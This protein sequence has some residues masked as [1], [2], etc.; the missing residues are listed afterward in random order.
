MKD[1]KYEEWTAEDLRSEL[2]DRKLTKSGTKAE[3]AARLREYDD[4]VAAGAE[5][6]PVTECVV[7]GCGRDATKQGLCDAHWDTH[8]GFAIKEES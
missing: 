6:E 3:M 2:G 1:T 5:V 7:D 4:A 8:R